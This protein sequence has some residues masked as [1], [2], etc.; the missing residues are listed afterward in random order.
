MPVPFFLNLCSSIEWAS[1]LT[2]PIHIATPA[3]V[4]C[5]TYAFV[6]TWTTIESSPPGERNGANEPLALPKTAASSHS[7]E[8]IR[9]SVKR[10]F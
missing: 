7:G 6:E 9:R 1:P 3:G 4:Y 10:R 8:R 2:L 5:G